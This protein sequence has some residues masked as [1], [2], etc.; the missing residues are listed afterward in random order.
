MTFKRI[1]IANRG[2]IARRIIRTCRKMGIQ[3][4]CLFSE[5]EKLLPHALEGD[6]GISLGSG[7]LSETYLN[8]P[9][10]IQVAKDHQASAVHPGYGFLSEN[11]QFARG[12]EKAG[13]TFIGP[14]PS[15]IEEMGD[16][17]ASKVMMQKIGVP[18][19]PGGHLEK[20]DKDFLW[21]ESLE[22]GFPVLIKAVAGGGGK[23]LRMVSRK[24]DFFKALASAKREALKA[25]GD[26]RVLVEK[27]IE[28]PRHI[29]I[30][31]MSDSHGHH[32]HL[33]DRECSIQR[34]YQ[35]IVEEA[36][37]PYLP[38]KI[39]SQ[40]T[41]SALKIARHINYVGAGTV[42]FILD[43]K[44][45]YYFLEMN[46]RI[47][48]EHP[49]TEMITGLDLVELQIR[50]AQGEKLNLSQ[51]ELHSVGHALEVRLYAEDPYN[52]FLP[53]TGQIEYLGDLSLD[54]ARL[55][56]SYEKGNQVG[57]NFDPMLA[58]LI[59]HSSE[60]K[61][62]IGKMHMAL[63][64]I[65]FWGIKTN[66]SYLKQILSH[67]AFMNGKVDTHFIKIYHDDLVASSEKEKEW[68][69]LDKALGAAACLLATSRNQQS[70]NTGHKNFSGPWEALKGFKNT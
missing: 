20:Q 30:Q 23:G 28:N 49:V 18:V 67:P 37:T 7:P 70:K 39:R 12:V 21:K 52:Q 61:Q 29:E 55:E 63:G 56:S 9:K 1:L 51:K 45:K 15:A 24:Q 25:F 54:S 38:D 34:R 33:F 22:M 60:R 40:M 32:F 2:E 16:K 14:P 68:G 8:I 62:A 6:F 26:D 59:V 47:Q 3:T 36:P 58:K 65:L 4:V 64:Q 43:Q 57:I 66:R 17:L 41:A 35:K 42:E 11:P 5:E 10:V 69:Q 48:V 27:L 46:T 50:V 31:V 13:L 19:I 44:G 53:S